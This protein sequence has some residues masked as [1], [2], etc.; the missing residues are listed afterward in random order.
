LLTV[1]SAGGPNLFKIRNTPRSQAL[2]LQG[3]RK[4]EEEHT[5]RHTLK[6]CVEE[7][8]TGSRFTYAEMEGVEGG[9]ESRNGGRAIG[10]RVVRL[11]HESRP[12]DVIEWTRF[13]QREG[14][15]GCG[16]TSELL[17]DEALAVTVDGIEKHKFQG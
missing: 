3:P 12:H 2:A 10:G 11:R 15:L 1:S 14:I 6:A 4:G 9:K 13:V 8:R 16:Y 7:D 17:G 5:H